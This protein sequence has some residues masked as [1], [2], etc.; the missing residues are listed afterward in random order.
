MMDAD[1]IK[2]VSEI[3][4]SVKV[5]VGGRDRGR[6]AG[7]DELGVAYW[8]AVLEIDDLERAVHAAW[9]YFDHWERVSLSAHGAGCDSAALDVRLALKREA[10]AALRG[11]SCISERD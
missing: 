5:I 8:L 2:V 10:I 9:R 7:P 4:K 6:F 11:L 3:G 1:S